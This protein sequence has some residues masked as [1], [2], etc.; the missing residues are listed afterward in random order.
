MDRRQ[1]KTRQAIFKAFTSL[2]LHKKCSA[3][4][5]GEII[6]KADVGRA[7]FYSHFE[8][9]DFLLK[10]LCKELFCHVF[11]NMNGNGE[12]HSH[13]FNCDIKE[14]IFL[15]LFTHLEKNDNGISTLLMCENNG[16]FLDYFKNELKKLIGCQQDVLEYARARNIPESFWINHVSGCFVETCKWWFS[17]KQG[18]SPEEIHRY[19]VC[20]MG[21]G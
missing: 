3:I 11:D 4:T 10:E 14:D 13:I 20:A 17:D 18:C 9:K 19:F 15:H 7:T 2:L 12:G 21:I 8:T 6:E 5:V 1:R 16:L